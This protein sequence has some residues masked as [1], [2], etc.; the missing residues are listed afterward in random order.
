MIN[1]KLVCV[2]NL[3]ERFW[4]EASKE[5]EKRLNRFC[6][7]SI[8]EVAE[9]NKYQ[10]I[11]KIVSLEGE[12]ILDKLSGKP[13]LLDINGKELS[14]EELSSY[15]NKLAQENSTITFVIGGSYGCSN[16]VKEKIKDK[17]SFG[18]IT[19]PHNLARIVLLEQIYRA[20]MISSG[21]K[22]HK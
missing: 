1:I 14:S 10:D 11:N 6:K 12:E 22:Y 5:Y 2:G 9:E 15:L 13:I 16:A 18:K 20:F 19:L 17:L 21:N 4:T 7:L 8:V 3:K